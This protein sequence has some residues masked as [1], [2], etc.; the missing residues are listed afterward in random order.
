MRAWKE[1]KNNDDVTICKTSNS[2]WYIN[3]GVKIERFKNGKIE[4]KNTMT[5][6]DHYENLSKDMLDVFIYQGWQAGAF[7]VCID[8]HHKR[9]AVYERLKNRAI[10]NKKYEVAA[11][12]KESREKVI[13]KM[14]YYVDRLQKLL[15]SL[16][17]LNGDGEIKSPITQLN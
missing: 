16:H 10:I 5:N 17:P 7:C 1:L 8:V 13:N 14:N 15:P 3:H 4:V 12:L 9:A 11:R 6:S 2:E